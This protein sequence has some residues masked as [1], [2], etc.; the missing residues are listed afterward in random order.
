VKR[1]MAILF[2]TFFLPGLLIAQTTLAKPGQTVKPGVVQQQPPTLA[3][4]ADPAV[5][6]AVSKTISS[7]TGIITL[8]GQVCNQGVG[9]YGG[10][11]P[12]D[13][14]FMVYTWHP[15]LTI[16]QEGNVQT[17]G[18]TPVT[19][20]LNRNEC[21]AVTQTYQIPNVIDW[22]YVTPQNGVPGGRRQAFK[23]FVIRVQ[24]SPTVSFSQH[25][26]CNMAN[27]TVSMDLPYVEK[28]L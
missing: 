13:A 7:G 25:E 23:Q 15:P 21:R 22:G 5:K 12:I 6:L 16:A 20:P 18:H 8:N 14:F 19:T 26:D 11:T 4:C 9:T 2:L 1:K 28:V 3:V 10:T 17:F 27:D 24:K